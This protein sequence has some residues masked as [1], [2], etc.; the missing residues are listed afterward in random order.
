M[1]KGLA[2][3]QIKGANVR[4]GWVLWE[5]GG[6]RLSDQGFVGEAVFGLGVGVKRLWRWGYLKEDCLF[7]EE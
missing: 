1:G 6:G 2:M 5:G 7:Y 3:G 4:N